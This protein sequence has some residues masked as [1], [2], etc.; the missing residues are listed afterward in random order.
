MWEKR[1]VSI[2]KFQGIY[3]DSAPSEVG[4]HNPLLKC[5]VHHDLPPKSTGWKVGIKRVSTHWVNPT[6][7]TSR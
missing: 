1:Q 3:I 2:A 6:N 4:H 5:G 7:T